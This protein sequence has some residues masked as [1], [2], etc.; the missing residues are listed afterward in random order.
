[1]ISFSYH[2]TISLFQLAQQKQEGGNKPLLWKSFS[3]DFSIR[4]QTTYSTTNFIHSSFKKTMESIQENIKIFARKKTIERHVQILESYT[5]QIN[6]LNSVQYEGPLSELNSL[7]PSLSFS[8]ILSDEQI[9]RDTYF[10]LHSAIFLT[11]FVG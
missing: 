10:R 11:F 5:K 8:R 9:I 1:M 2:L 7:L 3:I 4:S 6:Q